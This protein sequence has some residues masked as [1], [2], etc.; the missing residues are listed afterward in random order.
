M[1]VLTRKNGQNLVIGDNITIKILDI[2]GDTVRIGIDAPKEVAVHRQEVY[3]AIK[4]ANKGA[5]M[6][7]HKLPNLPGLGSTEDNNT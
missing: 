4:Q 2:K 3:E 6:S 7:K 1:L 5:A